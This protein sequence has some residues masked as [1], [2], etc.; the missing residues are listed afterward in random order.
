MKI[1]CLLMFMWLLIADLGFA[2]DFE[3]ENEP[4]TNAQFEAH[5]KKLKAKEKKSKI[6]PILSAVEYLKNG[7]KLDKKIFRV[8]VTGEKST[9]V[10]VLPK[11]TCQFLWASPGDIGFDNTGKGVY[12]FK[13]NY[14]V[15]LKAL[16]LETHD[17]SIYLEVQF[18]GIQEYVSGDG[19]SAYHPVFQVLREY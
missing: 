14:K 7:A 18:I 4:I 5:Q 17:A 16:H 12:S 15:C 6:P 3:V 2:K 13:A 10:E 11:R 9:N 19:Q 8:M 1:L